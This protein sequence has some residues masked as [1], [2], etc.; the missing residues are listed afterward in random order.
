[1]FWTALVLKGFKNIRKDRVFYNNS[2]IIKEINYFNP[3][4]QLPSQHIS[5]LYDCYQ[6]L[7][8]KNI[9]M[10]SDSLKKI[11]ISMCLYKINTMINFPAALNI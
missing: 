6:L 5:I 3:H 7:I 10:K 8:Q 9:Q 2:V 1:M 11:G 4:S